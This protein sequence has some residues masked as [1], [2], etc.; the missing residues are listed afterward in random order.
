MKIYVQKT[1]TGLSLYLQDDN[2]VCNQ[3]FMDASM[4]NTT[5]ELRLN[6]QDFEQVRDGS[7]FH[8]RLRVKGVPIVPE[9]TSEGEHGD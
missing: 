4:F 6:L 9:S 3:W 5:G 1:N 2:G 7:R 8:T